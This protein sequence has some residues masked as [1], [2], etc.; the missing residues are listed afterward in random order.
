MARLRK[1]VARKSQQAG[2]HHEGDVVQIDQLIEDD[3]ARYPEPEPAPE[4]T[5]SDVMHAGKVPD[6]NPEMVVNMQHDK[7]FIEFILTQRHSEVPKAGGRQKGLSLPNHEV[8]CRVI[9][10]A[11]NDLINQKPD[12]MMLVKGAKI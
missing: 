1:V 7:N 6:T 10:Q 2:V 9:A 12:W 8:F 4:L 11:T 5:M 3:T